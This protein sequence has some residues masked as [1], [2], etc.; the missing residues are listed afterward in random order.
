MEMQK[1]IITLPQAKLWWPIWLPHCPQQW[2]LLCNSSPRT[3]SQFL[4]YGRLH[5][6]V[7]LFFK[8]TFFK[9][10]F[11]L[12][13]ETFW[14]QKS[15]WPSR[16]GTFLTGP[17][18]TAWEFHRSQSQQ[19]MQRCQTACDHCFEYSATNTFKK[20]KIKKKKLTGYSWLCTENE[21]ASN[22]GAVHKC[23][24]KGIANTCL[25]EGVNSKRLLRC[26]HTCFSVA[27]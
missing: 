6:P 26:F 15:Y 18:D 4:R 9:V 13:Q 24:L 1:L 12:V 19:L 10:I 17:S 2:L 22:H 16:H 20:I 11:I 7:F 27:M 21:M 14:T 25:F 8:N 23:L 5:L 3:L